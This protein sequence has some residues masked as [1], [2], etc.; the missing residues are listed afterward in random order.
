MNG[1][2]RDEEQRVQDVSVVDQ[3]ISWRSVDCLEPH[4][5]CT[6]AG[7]TASVESLDVL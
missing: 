6:Q 5:Q 2:T 3:N 7:L 1:T 4:P